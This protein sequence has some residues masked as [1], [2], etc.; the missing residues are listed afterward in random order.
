MARNASAAARG[1]EFGQLRGRFQAQAIIDAPVAGDGP[2]SLGTGSRGEPGYLLAWDKGEF[3][4]FVHC[5]GGFL[6]EG[7]FVKIS[8]LAKE[9]A[10]VPPPPTGYIQVQPAWSLS[11]GLTA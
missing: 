3:V 2:K 1:P 11:G 8:P 10:A 5:G 4:V 7:C 9:S 6:W